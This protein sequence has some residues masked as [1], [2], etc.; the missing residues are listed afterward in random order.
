MIKKACNGHN[1]TYQDHKGL[2]SQEEIYYK[3][4]CSYRKG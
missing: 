2:I 3:M 4:E 1:Y